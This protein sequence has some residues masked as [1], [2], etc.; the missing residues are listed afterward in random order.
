M[1]RLVKIAKTFHRAHIRFLGPRAI[2][3]AMDSCTLLIEQQDKIQN[4]RAN[5]S[6][7]VMVFHLYKKSFKR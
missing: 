4:Q 2:V 3:Q 6:G 1:L 5:F 7:V